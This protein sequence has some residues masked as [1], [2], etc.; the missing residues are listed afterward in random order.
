MHDFSPSGAGRRAVGEMLWPCYSVC[1]KPR[2][3]LLVVNQNQ[4]LD[5]L[6]GAVLRYNG[7]TGTF[8]KGIVPAIDT[9]SPNADPNAPFLPRGMILWDKQVLFVAEFFGVADAPGRL[10]SFTKN[11]KFLSDLTPNDADFPRE[12]FHPRGV[13]IGPDGLL[14][15]SIFPDPLNSPLGGYV[16]R[17]NPKTGAFIDVF[18]EPAG[19]LNS[20][21]PKVWSS[22]PTATFTSPAFERTIWITTRF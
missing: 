21:G 16:L 8:Q 4:G 2:R 22:A 6:S 13:V 18:I 17:F 10:L 9:S 1:A 20:T 19:R 14:Y 11:G 5:P 15:V 3:H 7:N 12:L